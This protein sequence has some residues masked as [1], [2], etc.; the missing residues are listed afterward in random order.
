MDGRAEQFEQEFLAFRPQL[1]SYL[2]RL[3]TN[4]QDA[5]DLLQD[6]FIRVVN[7]IE[8]FRGDAGFKTWVFQIATNLARDHHRVKARWGED[9]MDLVKDAHVADPALFARKKVVLESDPEGKFVLSEHLN[10]CFNCTVKTLLVE[11]QVCLWLKEVYDFKVSEIMLILELSEGKVKHA[12]TNARRHLSRIF[13]H[14]CVLINKQGTCSQCTGLNKMYNP[15]Q[16]AHVEANKLKLLREQEGKNMEQLL[17]LRMQLVKSI[18]PMSGKTKALHSYLIEN[19]PAWAK[20][21]QQIQD[22][23]K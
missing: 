23:K 14:K 15:E 11:E 12:L 7:K 3:T 9:W 20:K 18:D 2:F 16:D 17:E 10:Y 6:T 4:R 19:S 13:Q 1:K 8:T 22:L 5:E 21:Q